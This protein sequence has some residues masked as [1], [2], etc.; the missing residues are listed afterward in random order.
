VKSA[1]VFRLVRIVLLLMAPVSL[2]A[3]VVPSA[4]EGRSPF[5][6]G[7]GVSSFDV[8]WEH[9]RMLG[10]TLWLDWSPRLGPRL[11]RGLGLEAEARDISLARSSTQP[12]FRYD[13]AGGGPIYRWPLTRTITFYGKY[14][15]AFGSVDFGPAPTPPSGGLQPVGKP[16]THDTRTLVGAGGGLEFRIFRATRARVDYEY[17]AWPDLFKNTL[18]PQGFTAG[19]EYDFRFLHRR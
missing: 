9:G 2:S 11:L 6:A 13:T 12:D 18:D 1:V 17:Q 14:V 5:A 3:Q 8:D 10:G 4:T 19:V 7:V 16:Y 15:E